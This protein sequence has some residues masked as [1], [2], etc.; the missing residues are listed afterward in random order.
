[1]VDVVNERGVP[2]LELL[3]SGHLILLH[4]VAPAIP[5]LVVVGVSV[6]M[7]DGTLGVF[8]VEQLGADAVGP[9]IVFGMQLRYDHLLQ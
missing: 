6:L 4:S 5:S 2:G 9:G 3:L 1:M 8:L 7:L